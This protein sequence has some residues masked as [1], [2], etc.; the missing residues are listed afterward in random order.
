MQDKPGFLILYNP[1]FKILVICVPEFYANYQ[2]K[3]FVY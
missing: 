2:T 1:V 3:Q